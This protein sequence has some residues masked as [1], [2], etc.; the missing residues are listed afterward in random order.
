EISA[1]QCYA[2]GARFAILGHSERRSGA[3]FQGQLPG[4]TPQMVAQKVEAAL[5]GRLIPIVCVG[6][7]LEERQGGNLEAV[8]GTQLMPVLTVNPSLFKS[9][10]GVIA[11][12][13][14]WAI[15]TGVTAKPEDAEAAC[16]YIRE[17]LHQHVSPEAALNTRI[18]YGGSVKPDNVDALMSMPNIDGGLVG[19]AF[20]QPISALQ[21][22]SF[23]LSA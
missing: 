18:L 17:L 6:E 22:I 1:E 20:L 11:Y 12:E 15:G 7:T 19:G 9:K 13:P 16:F 10:K 4:E 3:V 5:R 2:A 14:V 21:L 8:I 23:G